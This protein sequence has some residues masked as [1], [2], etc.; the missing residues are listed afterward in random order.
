MWTPD[1]DSIVFLSERTRFFSLWRVPANGGKIRPETVY[2]AIGSYD[3]D[4]RRF[5][6]D[7]GANGEPLAVWRADLASAGG[8]IVDNRK[9]IATQFPERNAQPS[10]DGARI[11]WAERKGG[12]I[13]DY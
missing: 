7:E 3:K 10:P 12:G 8:K 1:G 4:G 13:E 9:L 6:Y 5:V 11:V 2:P